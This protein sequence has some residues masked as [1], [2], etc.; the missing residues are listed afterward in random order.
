MS[1]APRLYQP[2][3]GHNLALNRIYYANNN[4]L[5][6]SGKAPVPSSGLFTLYYKFLKLTIVKTLETTTM[7][8]KPTTETLMMYQRLKKL[9]VAQNSTK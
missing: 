4:P 3:L 6:G 7:H 1:A 2:K 8:E 5:N 9:E